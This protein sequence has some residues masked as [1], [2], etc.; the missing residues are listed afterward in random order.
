MEKVDKKDLHARHPRL[1]PMLPWHTQ[2][3]WSL[4]FFLACVQQRGLWLT[5]FGG[6]WVIMGL[7]RTLQ[8]SSHP[9]FGMWMCYMTFPIHLSHMPISCSHVIIVGSFLKSILTGGWS[10]IPQPISRREVVCAPSACNSLSLS[11]TDTGKG[12][13]FL[14]ASAAFFQVL[15]CSTAVGCNIFNFST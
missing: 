3:I 7:F 11:L 13:R 15:Y 9:Y 2:T 5:A 14:S 1:H 12:M 10:S 6:S 4:F 8:A